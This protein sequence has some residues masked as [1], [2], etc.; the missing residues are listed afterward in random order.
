MNDMSFGSSRW[1]EVLN[2]V[3]DQERSTAS[4]AAYKKLLE[5][6]ST[7]SYKNPNETLAPEETFVP[8]PGFVIATSLER[9]EK[10]TIGAPVGVFICDYFINVCHC[11]RIET[12]QSE[13]GRQVLEDKELDTSKPYIS[14][15]VRREKAI[16]DRNRVVCDVLVHSLFA[17]RAKRDAS[18]KIYLAN[19]VIN[20]LEPLEILRHELFSSQYSAKYRVSIPTYGQVISTSVRI[21]PNI[22]FPQLKYKGGTVPKEHDLSPSASLHYFES[23]TNANREGERAENVVDGPSVKKPLIQECN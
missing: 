17:R 23:F 5:C 11:E 3:G 14:I 19:C 4:S 12:P 9:T 10:V 20:R 22:T 16:K 1:S 15:G 6:R 21:S 8:E 7:P 13:G 18:F 2:V